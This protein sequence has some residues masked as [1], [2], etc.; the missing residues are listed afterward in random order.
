MWFFQPGNLQLS[1]ARMALQFCFLPLLCS[2]KLQERRLFVEE[3]NEGLIASFE[4]ST[5]LFEKST[6]ERM[7]R[8]FHTL[9]ESVILNPDQRLSELTLLPLAE[10]DQILVTW[11]DTQSDYPRD[12]CVHELFEAQV[13]RTP[14]AVAVTF[15]DFHLTYRELNQRANMLAHYL[16]RLEVTQEELVAISMERSLDMIVGL[17]GILKS[18]GTYVPLD[19]T[20]PKERHA[21]MLQDIQARI[22]LTQ[23]KLTSELPEHEAKVICLD[24]DWEAIAKE[25]KINPE[26]KATSQN[27]AYV[28]YTSGSTGIPKGAMI[29]HRAICNHMLWMQADFPLCED[30]RMLQKTPFS[31]DASVWEFFAPLLAGARKRHRL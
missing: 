15:G 31:F 22:L 21:F 13:E 29:P 4:Y 5:D 28:M 12:K 24:S 20:Y 1:F 30:D 23:E 10:R 2:T 26:N 8:H 14:E 19:P 3:A 16:Q 9:L 6:I 18:G 25:S 11:N 17:L 7:L 27:L